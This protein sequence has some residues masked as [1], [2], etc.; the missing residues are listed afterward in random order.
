MIVSNNASD[1]WLP[2]IKFYSGFN[3]GSFCSS[4]ENPC[5]I[6]Q[7]F[8]IRFDS[9]L[10]SEI[11]LRFFPVRISL[12]DRGTIIAHGPVIDESGGYGVSLFQIADEQDISE[13]TSEDPVVKNGVGHYEHYVMLSLKSRG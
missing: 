11:A 12:M 3:P 5:L 13:L 10:K 8:E 7:G 2:I 9:D 1:S 4:N 6:V